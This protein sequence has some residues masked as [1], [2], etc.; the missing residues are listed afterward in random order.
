MKQITLPQPDRLL[1]DILRS[2]PFDL[3][4]RSLCL[5]YRG[6]VSHGTHSAPTDPN[7]ID[8]VDIFG[9][10]VPPRPY[11]IGL[12]TFEQFESKVDKWDVL[13]YD[14]RKFV[15]L[16]IKMNP[17]VLNALWTPEKFYLRETP[18]WQRI[19]EN[20]SLF[21]SKQI[22]KSFCG[23]SQAQMH[24]ME[25]MVHNGYMGEKRKSLV[26]KH[27]YDTKNGQ[28]L[29]RLLRQGIEFLSTGELNV[30]RPDA[31]ELINIKRGEWSID[32]I[33]NEA[34]RL[35][36]LIEEAHLNSKLPGQPD[37]MSINL[38]L[39]EILMENLLRP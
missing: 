24:K 35:F 11:I 25:S 3:W 27:G 2:A 30:E 15:R 17:N 5:M 14:L 19:R 6:S 39:Q 37:R 16:L 12:D 26:E 31:Q 23:Y 22:F 20:R 10:V 29:I 38:L 13:C 18:A 34:K 9:V 8:D 4:D 33:H 28:H 32:R 36:G 7:S 21:S 1:N